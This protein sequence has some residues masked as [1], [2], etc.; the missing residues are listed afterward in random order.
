MGSVADIQAL[1]RFFQDKVPD[2]DSNRHV[3]DYANDKSRWF[4]ANELF[5]TIH[6]MNLK[7]IKEGDQD[8][9]CQYNFEEVCA[10]TLYNI[11][12]PDSPFDPD[13]PYWVIKNALVLAKALGVPA[14]EVVNIVAPEK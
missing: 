8:K 14:E 4:M 3:Q 9:A 1:L 6:E 5:A 2:K 10:K 11:T 7:T 12:G 13:S